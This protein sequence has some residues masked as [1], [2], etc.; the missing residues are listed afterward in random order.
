MMPK[1]PDYGTR[2]RLLA[3][4]H[5][6]AKELALSEESYR[7]LLERIGGE[8]SAA[9]LDDKKLHAVVQELDRLG[10]GRARRRDERPMASRL[11]ALWITAWNLDAIDDPSEVGL[12]LFVQRQTGRERLQFCSADQLALA[13]EGVKAICARAGFESPAGL[14]SLETK[15]RLVREQW[16]RLHKAGWAR[17]AGDNGL[18]GYAHSTWCVPNARSIDQ[19]E[20]GHLDQLATRLGKLVRDNRL[21]R[22]RSTEGYAD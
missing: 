3:R 7:D 6:M 13:I 20:A 10:A 22:R 16:A 19:M 11:R 5:A 1:A 2:R 4:V 14:G 18:T 15:R 12:Q 8:R 21:G 17:V 9:L